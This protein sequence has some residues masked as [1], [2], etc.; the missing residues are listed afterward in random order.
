MRS[1]A[2]PLTSPAPRSG[3]SRRSES[4][5]FAPALDLSGGEKPEVGLSVPPLSELEVGVDLGLEFG[6]D[7]V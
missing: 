1:S 3:F 2:S 5:F 4:G 6:A 7:G